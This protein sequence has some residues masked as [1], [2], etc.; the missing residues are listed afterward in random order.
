[1]ARQVDL[2]EAKAR[3]ELASEDVEE[4]LSGTIKRDPV[5]SLVV[6]LA[7]G[8]VVGAFP[9][10]RNALADSLNLIIKTWL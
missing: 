5:T 4:R 10:V 8:F 6:A 1:M 2:K 7:S 3:L 9:K